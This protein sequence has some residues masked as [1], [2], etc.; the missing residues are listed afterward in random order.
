MH[1]GRSQHERRLSRV[2]NVE[3]ILLNTHKEHNVENSTWGSTR[4]L[5]PVRQGAQWNA[6]LHMSTRAPWMKTRPLCPLDSPQALLKLLL[7]IRFAGTA[8]AQAPSLPIVAASYFCIVARL[9]MGLQGLL[10]PLPS[11]HIRV[12][13]PEYAGT[14]WG[15]TSENLLFVL[16]RHYCDDECHQPS[17][18]MGGLRSAKE[19]LFP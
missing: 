18:A 7:R 6:I 1:V 10:Y 3:T 9:S 14:T 2:V 12:L 16:Q 11:G 15:F 5:G 19:I 8:S 13:L 4:A 17:D